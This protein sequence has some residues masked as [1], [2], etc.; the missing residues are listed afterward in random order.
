MEVGQHGT[1]GQGVKGLAMPECP[2][3]CRANAVMGLCS[4]CM[5]LTT[6]SS[7]QACNRRAPQRLSEPEGDD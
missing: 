1:R 2:G 5:P 7:V 3:L 4:A 6:I